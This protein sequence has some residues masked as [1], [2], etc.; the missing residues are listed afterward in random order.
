M[1][2]RRGVVPVQTGSSSSPWSWPGSTAQRRSLAGSIRFT[3]DLNVVQ[4][5]LTLCLGPLAHAGIT[6]AA[7]GG[8][9]G[10]D[11]PVYSQCEVCTLHDTGEGS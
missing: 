7:T 10:S 11:W 8:L 4:I 5:S 2:G 6:S 1:R 9:A 3:D